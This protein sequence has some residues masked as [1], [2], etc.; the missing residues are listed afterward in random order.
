[1]IAED[2][3][4]TTSQCEGISPRD[5]VFDTNFVIPGIACGIKSDPQMVLFDTES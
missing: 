5:T 2:Q 3:H 1:M 4:S